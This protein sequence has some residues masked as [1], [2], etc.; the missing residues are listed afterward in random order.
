MSD[1]YF[2]IEKNNGLD[3]ILVN[4]QYRP[5]INLIWLGCLMIFLA[6]IT[7]ILKKIYE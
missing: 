1:L 5:L 2:A 3:S 7:A 6:G 4:I